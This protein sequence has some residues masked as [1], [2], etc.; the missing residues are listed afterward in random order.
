LCSDLYPGSEKQD[1]NIASLR[2]REAFFDG[3]PFLSARRRGRQNARKRQQRGT[4]P[5]KES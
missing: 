2:E 4:D 1:P 3:G 5:R